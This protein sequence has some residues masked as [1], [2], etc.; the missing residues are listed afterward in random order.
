MS[1]FLRSARLCRSLRSYCS[2]S[3]SLGVPRDTVFALSSGQ[4]K[5]GKE[6]IIFVV[7]EELAPL[8]LSKAWLL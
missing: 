4:G 3:G 8:L 2:L 7:V 1:R 6:L 5:C